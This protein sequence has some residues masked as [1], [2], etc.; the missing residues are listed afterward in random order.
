MLHCYM[1]SALDG[2]NSW[3][4]VHFLFPVF[5]LPPTSL[6][7]PSHL[8]I[9]DGL[10]S[11]ACGQWKVCREPRWWPRCW[12][13]SRTLCETPCQ[14][15]PPD[16]PQSCSWWPPDSPCTGW[17][18]WDQMSVKAHG[19]SVL[20]YLHRKFPF[21]SANIFLPDLSCSDLSLHLPSFPGI[22]AEHQQSRG[23]TVQ[24]GIIIIISSVLAGIVMTITACLNTV[25]GPLL[26][27][28]H[29]VGL[30]SNGSIMWHCD[31]RR[32]W[33]M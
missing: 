4:F 10:W 29:W 7:P 2:F 11:G 14:W 3:Y 19:C 27:S 24:P 13:V 1:V 15:R 17:L 30:L 31:I 12:R 5:P 9:G 18:P 8:N 25:S 16:R 22:S 23:E 21:N 20:A 32:R 26:L 6:S 28:T 33:K